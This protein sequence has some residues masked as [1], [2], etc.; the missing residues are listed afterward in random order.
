MNPKNTNKKYR[1]LPVGKTAFFLPTPSVNGCWICSYITLSITLKV[2]VA[3]RCIQHWSNYCRDNMQYPLCFPWRVWS[4]LALE[5]N[6]QSLPKCARAACNVDVGLTP[7]M[8]RAWSRD[9][10]EL[11]L[12]FIQSMHSLF[13]HCI[14]FRT[15]FMFHLSS[16]IYDTSWSFRIR[17]I[18]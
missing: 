13:N 15:C 8:R 7:H 16:F 11:Y 6:N 1:I 9:G 14:I 12:L 10:S 3:L 18:E 2:D 4:N 5:S 17:S